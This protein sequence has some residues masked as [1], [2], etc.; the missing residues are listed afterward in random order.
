MTK[1][2]LASIH[3]ILIPIIGTRLIMPPVLLH[4]HSAGTRFNPP[5]LGHPLLL[6]PLQDPDCCRP[7]WVGSSPQYSHHASPSNCCSLSCFQDPPPLHKTYLWAEHARFSRRCWE[8]SINFRL[9]RLRRITDSTAV[10]SCQ[11]L[12]A[13]PLVNS[14]T[15]HE[16]SMIH[17]GAGGFHTGWFKCRF[18]NSIIKFCDISNWHIWILGKRKSFFS[19]VRQ[20]MTG[21]LLQVTPFILGFVGIILFA[22]SLYNKPKNSTS[23]RQRKTQYPW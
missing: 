2:P 8:Y 10:I 13:S 20:I 18:H 14:Q 4:S 15:Q 7:W 6:F 16:P 5:L 23:R 11:C 9:L 1:G 17:D 3:H 12:A 19:C 21:L 22:W